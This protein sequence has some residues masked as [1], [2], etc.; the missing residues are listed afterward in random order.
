MYKYVKSDA[1]CSVYCASTN[2]YQLPALSANFQLGVGRLPLTYDEPVYLKFLT[3]FGTHVTTEVIM[4]ALFGQESEITTVAWDK[5]INAGTNVSTT[6]GLAAYSVNAGGD[7]TTAQEK[8]D[9][10]AFSSVTTTQSVYA[11]GALPP[12]DG[13]VYTWAAG[14]M[15][16]PMPIAYTLVVVSELLDAEHFPLDADI[17][18]KRSNVKQALSKYCPML[19]AQG[20]L[21]SCGDPAQP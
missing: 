4:G 2:P 15:D 11:V 10:Q 14:A 3:I 18:T 16:S 5:M 9:V 13:S 19:Q 1:R 17:D 20:K 6:A 7:L 8:S 21:S 12:A